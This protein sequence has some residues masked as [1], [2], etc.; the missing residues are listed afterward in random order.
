MAA[1]GH[2]PICQD[3]GIAVVFLK[4]GMNVRWDATLSLQ[5]MVDEGVRLGQPVKCVRLP[6]GR[7]GGTL[8]VGLSMP[9]VSA[10][11]AL[12]DAAL[13]TRLAGDMDVIVD[14]IERVRAK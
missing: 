1:E 13:E 14:A 6:D 9:Q 7:W 11:D 3:T 8:R 4:V 2:R 10:F 5:E 12:D